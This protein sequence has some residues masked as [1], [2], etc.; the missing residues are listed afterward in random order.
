MNRAERR[1]NK[2]SAEKP[3]TYTLTMDQIEK[4]KYD[5]VDE[6]TYKA[7]LMFLSIPVMVLHDKFGFGKQR[8]G[9]FMDYCLIWY[10]AVLH[11]EAG[12]MELVKVAKDECGINTINWEGNND[13]LTSRSNHGT[14]K[15]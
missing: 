15:K 5:A 13:R 6:A 9:K 2:L 8:L 3:K 1:K 10:E 7:F 4:I 14:G 12:L 11:D